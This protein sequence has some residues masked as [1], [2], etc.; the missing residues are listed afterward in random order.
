MHIFFCLSCILSVVYVQYCVMYENYD[1]ICTNFVCI[2]IND[3]G[4]KMQ[5]NQTTYWIVFGEIKTE[6]TTIITCFI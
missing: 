4:E 3:N 2:F 6:T 5:V 1:L